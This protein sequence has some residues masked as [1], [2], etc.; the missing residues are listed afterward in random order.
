MLNNLSKNNDFIKYNLG[1]IDNI[2]KG[3]IELINNNKQLGL[4]EIEIEQFNE[5]VSLI[6][7]TRQMKTLQNYLKSP[8]TKEK[9]FYILESLSNNI[10]MQEYLMD[11]GR[12]I[13]E[14]DIIFIKESNGIP[15]I[16]F[17]YIPENIREDRMTNNHKVDLKNIVLEILIDIED[18][19]LR[20]ESIQ[21]YQRN[22]LE[23][24][25]NLLKHKENKQE[26]KNIIPNLEIVAECNKESEVKVE[27]KDSGFFKSFGSR[28]KTKKRL[29]PRIDND[30]NKASNYL[31][32][33]M[34]LDNYDDT[35]LLTSIGTLKI[36]LDKNNPLRQVLQDKKTV[37]GRAQGCNIIL[38]SKIISKEHA[39]IIQDGNDFYI[40]DL[41]SKNGTFI[42]NIRLDPRDRVMLKNGEKF[43]LGNIACEFMK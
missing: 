36:H 2:N 37:I 13:L 34:L 10:R 1:N 42:N 26:V 18:D 17:I 8:L 9:A 28:L 22:G 6:Y 35:V 11:K 7:P 39:V 5:D 27:S 25:L 3:Q 32:E 33:T 30:I 20:S 15:S 41:N 14:K 31:Y 21:V 43:I 4:I 24:V 19:E 16:Y 29:K 23:K 12:V 38:N 40:S